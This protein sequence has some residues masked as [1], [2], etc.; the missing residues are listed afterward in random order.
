[1]SVGCTA[2]PGPISD[3]GWFLALQLCRLPV[4]VVASIHRQL[5]LHVLRVQRVSPDG[6]SGCLSGPYKCWVNDERGITHRSEMKTLVRPLRW[7][8]R[9][10]RNPVEGGYGLNGI[11]EWRRLPD[12]IQW[13]ESSLGAW[14]LESRYARSLF[15]YWRGRRRG[16][17]RAGREP[18]VFP[19]SLV[20]DV[21]IRRLMYD[22]IYRERDH[23]PKHWCEA[24][25]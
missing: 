9:R 19:D 23:V 3:G 7:L 18:R 12:E 20:P 17:C 13:I 4:Q 16:Q 14:M 22:G 25:V 8:V 24:L 6:W 11:V 1:M 15:H 10:L 21:W 5:G 2:V